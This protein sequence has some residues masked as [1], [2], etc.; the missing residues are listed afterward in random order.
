MSDTHPASQH[1]SARLDPSPAGRPD[2]AAGADDAF[3]SLV[4][5]VAD[6]APE[7]PASRDER[8]VGTR[9]PMGLTEALTELA[10]I[11]LT[12]TSLH[13]V[14]RRVAALA[15]ATVPGAAEVSV[16]L[17]D[18]DKAGTVAFTGDLAVQLDERQYEDGFGPCM[19]AAHQGGAI[20]MFDL[21]TEQRYAGFVSAARRAGVTG[22]L[23]VGMPVPGRVVGGLNIYEC[24]DDGAGHTLD[25]GS[26]VVAE[27]FAGYAAVAV[28]NAGLLH[29]TQ[30]FA[31][32]MREAMASRAVIEQ[33]KGVLVA[34]T[35]CTP[36]QA[37]AELARQSRARNRK[38]ALIAAEVLDAAQHPTPQSGTTPSP[39]TR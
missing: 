15:Q 14:M 35:A 10:A 34:L 5:E 1:D 13:E 3:A 4:D 28:A 21:A 12:D 7:Q 2:H 8:K 19:D 38:L 24:A 33:A 9:A 39:A 18:G 17:L 27:N 20:P 22:M 32:Q 36:D 25:E 23:S 37:F 29:T 31:E 11:S 16:T 6:E 26:V 30:R